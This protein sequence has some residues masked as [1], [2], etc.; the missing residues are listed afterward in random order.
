MFDII[1]NWGLVHGIIF[2]SLKITKRLNVFKS[3]YAKYITE[4]KLYNYIIN[5]GGLIYQPN[6]KTFFVK[7][8]NN[9]FVLRRFSSDLIVLN[10]IFI[11]HEYLPLIN[12]IK[13]YNIQANNII[14]VGSNTGFSSIYFYNALPGSKI[15][16]IEASSL[17]F[18]FLKENSMMNKIDS[19]LINK[20]LWYKNE[21]LS[22]DLSFRDGLP[23]SHKF[24]NNVN[25]NY[26][27]K[28]V[29]LN[30][31][32][33]EYNIQEISVL[34]IDIEGGEFDVFLKP[35]N[36][37]FLKITKCLAIEIHEEAGDEKALLNLFNLYGFQM[38]KIDECYFGVNQNL[39]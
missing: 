28:G 39:I 13:K 36:T 27:V 15:F 25:G 29:S 9:K 22:L 2:F 14:D 4:N 10:Q 7:Y 33:K 21:D 38:E 31:I 5:Y 3:L 12:L 1:R 20:A 17:N 16:S 23:W 34:K 30:H 19:V 37:D 18:F 24:S 32:L 6:Y 26:S 11:K 8:G 35:L